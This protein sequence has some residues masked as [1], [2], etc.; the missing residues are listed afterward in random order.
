M[1]GARVGNFTWGI[2]FLPG[3]RNKEHEIRT[4]MEQKQQLQLKMLF[5]T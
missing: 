2:F 4:K 1:V 3:K 5:I